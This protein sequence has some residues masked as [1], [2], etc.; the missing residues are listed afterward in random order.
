MIMSTSNISDK[1]VVVSELREKLTQDPNLINPCLEVIFL[2]LLR[3]YFYFY[4][5]KI[6]KIKKLILMLNLR[7]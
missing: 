2:N 5:L 7:N 3:L 4:L 6:F 1:K